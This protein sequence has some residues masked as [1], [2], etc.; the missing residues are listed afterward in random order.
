MKILQKKKRGGFPALFQ[1]VS[2][3]GRCGLISQVSNSQRVEASM[4]AVV[5]GIMALNSSGRGG[6]F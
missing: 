4:V 6:G 5:A 3:K 1:C 2:S